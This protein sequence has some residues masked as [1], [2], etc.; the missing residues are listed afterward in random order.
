MQHIC[1]QQSLQATKLPRVDLPI[2]AYECPTI[3]AKPLFTKLDLA[4]IL[5]E[6]LINTCFNQIRYAD[7]NAS[8]YQYVFFFK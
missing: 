7:D 3:Q 1:I 8:A 6:K 5:E 4:S 2:K